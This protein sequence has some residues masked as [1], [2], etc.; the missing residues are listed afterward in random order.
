MT[1]SSP[2]N[3]ILTLFPEFR[4][5]PATTNAKH[6][7]IWVELAV[8]FVQATQKPDTNQVLKD[9]VYKDD[10]EGLKGFILRAGVDG[11][12]NKDLLAIVFQEQNGGK[13]WKTDDEMR[14]AFDKSLI[15][16]VSTD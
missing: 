3:A 2:V 8:S 13:G 7:F 10:A 12:N 11:M 14:A 6:C 5:A 1:R 9:K 4:C 16:M 15:A